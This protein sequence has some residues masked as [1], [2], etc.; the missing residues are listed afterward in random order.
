[1][2]KP[3]AED[4]LEPI[5]LSH[6]PFLE[7]E[8]ERTTA[9]FR[10]LL[11]PGAFQTY[12]DVIIEGLTEHAVGVHQLARLRPPATPERSGDL[13]IQQPGDEQGKTGTG[14]A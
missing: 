1:M 3:R 6:D 4:D 13:L 8:V 7:A 12:R 2:T 11:P 9:P 5:D 14:G 10:A